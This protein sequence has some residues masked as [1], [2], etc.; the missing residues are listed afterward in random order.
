MEET[1]QQLGRLRQLM[2][3]VEEAHASGQRLSEAVPHQLTELLAGVGQLDGCQ[4]QPAAA[5][6]GSPPGA[7][8]RP[9]VSRRGH[10]SRGSCRSVVV[11]DQ[12]WLRVKKLGQSGSLERTC[13][14]EASHV[15]ET[16]G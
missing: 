1:R 10:R 11:T 16:T 13:W 9:E 5:A 7:G 12:S 6:D 2:S 15:L 4:Q 3:S 14:R 8:R